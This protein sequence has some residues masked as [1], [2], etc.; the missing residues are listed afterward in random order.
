MNQPFRD[1]RHH[2]VALAAT[3]GGD[4]GIQ[5]ELA[6][7]AQDGFD[8]AVRKSS[9]GAEEIVRR[10]QRLIAKQPAQGFNLSAGPVGEVGQGA[11]AGF[12]AFAP[13]FA[14]QDG[15]RG[16]AIGDG[17]DVHGSY[18]SYISS[19]CQVNYYNLHGNICKNKHEDK[20]CVINGLF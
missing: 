5:T 2:Q 15:G 18:Y 4:H 16:I 8:V 17:F 6:D 9:L 19:Y 20:S 12:L 7:R 13:A 3:L 10:N 1:H 11:F 14:Q